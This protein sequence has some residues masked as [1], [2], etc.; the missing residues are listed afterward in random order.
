M[1][2]W[3]Y[4]TFIK[5]TR[6]V[7]MTTNAVIKSS[8]Y[9]KSLMIGG[10]DCMVILCHE[11]P[12]AYTSKNIQ[13][14]VCLCSSPWTLETIKVKAIKINKHNKFRVII[15]VQEFIFAILSN[16]S[17]DSQAETR[18]DITAKIFVNLLS[19]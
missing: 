10:V 7:I 4:G 15:K 14:P 13:E 6:Y 17:T 5:A 1:M 3:R 18:V 8:F 16:L 19:L 2:P 12:K 11:G 9:L